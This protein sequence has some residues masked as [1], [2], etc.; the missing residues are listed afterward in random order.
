MLQGHGVGKVETPC[1]KW[2]NPARPVRDPGR[3]RHGGL[4]PTR[5]RGP[6]RTPPRPGEIGALPEGLECAPQGGEGRSRI[7]EELAFKL[8]LDWGWGW[9]GPKL[10]KGDPRAKAGRRLGMCRAG[11]S[12]G[13]VGASVHGAGGGRARR[14]GSEHGGLQPRPRHPPPPVV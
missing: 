1:S 6:T 3:M 4:T 8:S 10:R 11:S 12:S 7:R 9:G 13:G 14:S 2:K 5:P